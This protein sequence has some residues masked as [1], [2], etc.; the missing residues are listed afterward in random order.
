MYIFFIKS[1]I[2]SQFHKTKN[3]IKMF[4]FTQQKFNNIGKYIIIK[5]VSYLSVSNSE[6]KYE[7][8]LTNLVVTW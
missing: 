1:I 5:I 4:K 8:T 3:Y 7:Y 6:Y 2:C